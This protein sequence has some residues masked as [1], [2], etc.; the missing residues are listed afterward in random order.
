MTECELCAK[1][2]AVLDFSRVCCRVRFVLSLPTREMRL[3]W[4]DRWKQKD[5]SAMA[6]EIE[7]EVRA[8]WNER[9]R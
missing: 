6:E 1:Q 7:R 9:I 3:G 8:K 2:S 4:L 5:G